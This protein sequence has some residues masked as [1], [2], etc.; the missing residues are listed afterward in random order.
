M[1]VKFK[2]MLICERRYRLW[3]QGGQKEEQEGF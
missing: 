3:E 2:E 1:S